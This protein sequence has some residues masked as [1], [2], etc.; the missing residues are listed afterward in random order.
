MATDQLYDFCTAL[1]D[2][3][4]DLL[5]DAGLAVPSRVFVS[6]TTPAE[7]CDTL[8]AWVDNLGPWATP[9]LQDRAPCSF[10][11]SVGVNLRIIVCQQEGGNEGQPIPEDQLDTFGQEHH[12]R[13]WVLWNG[14]LALWTSG[15]GG[16]AFAG[17]RCETIRDWEMVQTEYFGGIGGWTISFEMQMGNEPPLGS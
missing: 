13:G 10:V 1:L 12:Q 17:R 11:T 9:G 16:S 14:L 4:A 3:A 2:D 5:S 7:D 8:A 6:A 15:S